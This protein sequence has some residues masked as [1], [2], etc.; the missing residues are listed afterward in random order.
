LPDDNVVLYRV[1]QQPPVQVLPAQHGVAVEE[2]VP[3][4]P[5]T[6]QRELLQMVLASLQVLLAQQG[7]PAAPH[8]WQMLVELS[9]AAVASLHPVGFAVVTEQQVSPKAPQLLQV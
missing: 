8:T 6:V 3:G 1:T 7:P 4:V 9:Q 2:V 5:H